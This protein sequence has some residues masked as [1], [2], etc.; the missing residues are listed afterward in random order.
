MAAI[1]VLD[2]AFDRPAA[3]R[4][5]WGIDRLYPPDPHQLQA[6][7]TCPCG[8]TMSRYLFHAA[9]LAAGDDTATGYAAEP[10]VACPE[11]GA[12]VRVGE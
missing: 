9:A 5:L 1:D 2:D 6:S 10:R 12:A 3:R 7:V 8:V 11:C 4:S